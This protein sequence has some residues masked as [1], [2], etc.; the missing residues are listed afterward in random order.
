MRIELTAQQKDDCAAFRAFARE[1]IMPEAD[2]YDQEECTPVEL[3]RKLA[4][5][6]YLGVLAP[7]ENGGAGMDMITF[8]L[9]NEEIGGACSSVRSLLTVH[10]M[11]TYAIAKW[12]SKRQK[13]T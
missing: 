2:R 4:Q 5:Q 8:G 7:V 1:A 11:V 10:S 3:I 13:A 9:L 12:G 6:G